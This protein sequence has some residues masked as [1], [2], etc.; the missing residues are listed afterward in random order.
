MLKLYSQIDNDIIKKFLKNKSDINKYDKQYNDN[1]LNVIINKK[2]NFSIYNKINNESNLNTL[3]YLFNHI[4]AGIFVKIKDNKIQ[5]FIPFENKYFKNNWSNNITLEGTKYNDIHDFISTRRLY[6]K[7]YNKYINNIQFWHANANIINNEQYNDSDGYIPHGILDYYN[8][9][10][11]T[12][13]YNTIGDCVV[14]INKRD[15]CVLQ[16]DLLEPYPALYKTKNQKLENTPS[17]KCFLQMAQQ[18]VHTQR[19]NCK[20][21]CRYFTKPFKNLVFNLLLRKQKS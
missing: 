13:K 6:L 8:I 17:W 4:S 11:E 20:K 7:R 15:S 10:D 21:L 12:L 1:I 9:I 2:L 19:K 14:F 3:L 5:A 16:K 18:S